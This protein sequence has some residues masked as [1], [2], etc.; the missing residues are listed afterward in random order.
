MET[1]PKLNNSKEVIAFL[2][3]QFPLCFIAEGEAKPL[4]I[5]IFQ[6]LVKRLESETCVSKTQLRSALRLYTTSWRYLY[7]IKVGAERV[8]LDGNSC[9]VLEQE[10]VDFAREQLEQAKL[11]VKAQKK[12]KKQQETANVGDKPS[13]PRF[14]AKKAETTK[15]S[16]KPSAKTANTK[17]KPAQPAVRKLSESDIAA[18]KP[19]QKIKVKAGKDAMDAVILEISKEGAKVQ[20]A[21]GMSLV[22]R[23]EHLVI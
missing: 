14:N 19:G 2:A 10:H 12:E 18:M 17:T 1:Q 15:A 23:P 13:K 8:D 11:R 20:L 16:A 22:V 7:G 21:S 4:K 9:G 5:G 3:K 6:D